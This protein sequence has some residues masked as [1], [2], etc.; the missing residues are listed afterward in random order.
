MKALIDS[1]DEVARA[2][3][4]IERLRKLVLELAV[5]GKLVEQDPNDE[6]A[7]VLLNKIRE[8]KNNHGDT[9]ARRGKGKKKSELPSITEDEKPFE[10]PKGWEWVRLGEL[11]TM[12]NGK[13]FKPSDWI[14]EGLPIIRIQNLNNEQAKF[15][16][17]N[18]NR[19]E[20]KYIV[21]R[22]DLLISWSGTP[23]TSFGAFR[24][25]GNKAALN[26]HINRVVLLSTELS[27]DY[28]ILTV[29]SQLGVLINSAHGA[30]GLQHVTMGQLNNLLL[31]LS[32]I[33]EQAR[34]VARVEE[35]IKAL[36]GLEERERL[37][38]EARRKALT[39][40]VTELTNAR[41]G[42]AG[43]KAWKRLADGFDCLVDSPDDVKE[44]RKAILELAVRGRLVE[45]DPK[46]EP[47]SVLLEKIA[48]EK[49]A[50]EGTKA[51]RGRGKKNTELPP[52]TDDEKPF[53]LPRGWEWV[54]L[55]EI[56]TEV[57]DGTHFTP[58]Y[59][60]KGIPFISIKDISEKG[61]DFSNTRL[62]SEE[63]HNKLNLRCN[64]EKGDLLICRIGTLGRVAIVE[65]DMAFSLFVS[66]GLLK[67][68]LLLKQSVSY[69][70][71]TLNSPTA[72]SNYDEIKAGGS[73]TIKL[74]LESIPMIRIPLPPLAEQN[75][76]VA[77]AEAL[78]K[79]CDELE[80]SLGERDTA[81]REFADAAVARALAG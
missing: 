79:V 38:K 66:V 16:F 57:T 9:E 30:V 19:V 73:H 55:G 2:P 59:L 71:I 50:H 5:Q 74:N 45:Q 39:A 63:E 22:D 25:S 13:A 10:L 49:D 26:Q 29:N 42:K 75:R 72:Y 4:G 81:A 76:I 7:S 44:L 24:W 64:P 43:S 6:P 58:T 56:L 47:A 62:I 65:S 60:S 53:E 36:D 3:G 51:R 40:V 52:I 41:A 77:R 54:R 69:L 35:L 8:D 37:A 11:C 28:F 27:K 80:L 14:P 12:T 68:P 78:L 23:G 70:R 31:P 33:A 17:C 61:L 46:D 48:K 15:N 32:P 18:A 34:I 67:T 1:F 20:E 21:D